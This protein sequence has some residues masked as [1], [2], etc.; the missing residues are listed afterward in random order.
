MEDYLSENTFAGKAASLVQSRN[1]S[2]T[3]SIDAPEGSAAWIDA[4]EA[5]VLARMRQTRIFGGLPNFKTALSSAER[6]ERLERLLK[7]WAEGFLCTIDEELFADI[8]KRRKP[9]ALKVPAG[10]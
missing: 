3:G 10:K 4:A 9:A 5:C 7:L 2:L 1:E 8:L 6:R